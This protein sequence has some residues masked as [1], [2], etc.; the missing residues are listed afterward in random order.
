MRLERAGSMVQP[1]DS[2]PQRAHL[3]ASLPV[4]TSISARWPATRHGICLKTLHID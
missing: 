2:H 4:V 3:S 1:G